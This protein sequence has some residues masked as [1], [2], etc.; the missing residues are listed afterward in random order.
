MTGAHKQ[1]VVIFQEKRPLRRIELGLRFFWLDSIVSFGLKGRDLSEVDDGSHGKRKVTSTRV[2]VYS[3]ANSTW[4]QT[5]V[6]GMNAKSALVW[7]GAQLASEIS[8]HFSASRSTYYC[9]N[10]RQDRLR[11][12][13]PNIRGFG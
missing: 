11:I 3:D 8:L 10:I 12:I 6:M 4:E 2:E 13:T 5:S 7:S 9:E 1:L